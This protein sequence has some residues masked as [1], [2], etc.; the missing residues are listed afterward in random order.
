MDIHFRQSKMLIMHQQPI[1][2]YL[3]EV[4]L[5]TSILF[6][7]LIPFLTWGKD[8]SPADITNP[9]IAN[10]KDYIADPANL[11][12]GAAKSETNSILW[13][14]RQKTGA[15]VAIAVVPNTGNYSEEDFATKLFDDW[16]LGKS[17]KDNGVLILIVPDQRAARIAT[18]YGVE[19]IIP[20]IAARKIISRSVA[21]YM[22]QGDI[23]G[24]VVNVAKEVSNV[25]SNPETVEELKSNRGESWEQVPESDLSTEDLII[26]F[27]CILLGV[28][29]VSVCMYVYD[30]NRLKKIDR[31]SQSRGW[32]DNLST[33]KW[34]AII[35]LGIG[36]F[37]YLLARKKY[38]NSR[39]QPLACPSCKGKMHKL[40]EEEDN[41]YLS[42]SQDL[43]ER[44]NSVDYDVWVCD[45]CGSIEK[46]AYPNK[47]SVYQECP[48]CHTK[49]MYLL[50]DHTVV[51]STTRSSGI[52]ER[53][54]DCKYCHNQT[55]KRYTIPKKEDHSAAAAIAAGALLGGGRSG[56]SGFGGGFGGGRTGGGGATGRW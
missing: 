16:K 49:S 26:F 1:I 33:Y 52:G 22:K 55:R 20:D 13:D 24:A 42:P 27:I 18:G 44:L 54:Y 25:L 45:D 31:Y 41:K 43:E 47:H 8:Y 4:K 9:N 21:P 37:P 34:L 56:G 5:L 50:K 30:N 19:G 32:Y 11:V 46:F 7:L 6:F 2:K 38:N 48:H 36:L 53:I 10:R 39:N 40:N 28:G 35:S 14:L 17:D 15:E 3:K 29:L 12:S 23:N 51:P